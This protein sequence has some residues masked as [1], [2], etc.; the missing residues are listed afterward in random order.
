MLPPFL[1]GMLPPLDQQAVEAHLRACGP[2]QLECERLKRNRAE[3]NRCLDILDPSVE[4]I[5]EPV[6]A[7]ASF[8]AQTFKPVPD[9]VVRSGEALASGYRVWLRGWRRVFALGMACVFCL[10]ALLSSASVRQAAAQW[11]SVFRVRTVAVIPV[12]PAQLEHLQAIE[13]L[14]NGGFLGQPEILRE[15]DG[16]HAMSN[17]SDAAELADFKVR[18][19]LV[20]PDGMEFEQFLVEE[21]PAVRYSIQRTMIQAVLEAVGIDDVPLPAAD[22]L[23]LEA[24]LPVSVT[25]KFRGSRKQLEIRQMPS[26]N[27]QITPAVDPALLGRIA[28]RLLGVPLADSERLVNSLDWTSTLLIPLPTSVGQFREIT[29]DGVSGVL[30][31]ATARSPRRSQEGVILWQ[32]DG[33]LYFVQGRGVRP[34]EMLRVADSLQ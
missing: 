24:D 31:E 26:P 17:L 32:R 27:L 34:I 13:D 10:T 5:P 20:Q 21:G 4:A 22:T 19:P 14:A 28:L 33:M 1:D 16:A 29:V 25:Q 15:P 30:I 11:L 9:P 6:G 8:Q 2:C 23:T 18:T 7:L 12:D 3:I